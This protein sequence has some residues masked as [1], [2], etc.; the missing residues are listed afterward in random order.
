MQ[1]FNKYYPPDYDPDKH[2]SLNSYR[3]THALGDR[4]RKLDQGILITRFELPF[5]IWCL[6]CNNHI[7]MGVRYNAEKRKIGNYYSTPMYAFRCKCHLC[8]NWFEIRTDPKNTRY[9]VEYGARQKMEDWNPEENGGYAIHDPE[10]SQQPVDPLAAIEKTTEAIKHAN[11]VGAPRLEELYDLSEHY[12]ADPYELSQKVRR[13]FREEKKVDQAQKK[14]DDAFKDK[15]AL[16]S[17][18]PLVA[19]KDVADEAKEEWRE[20]RR[21]LAAERTEVKPLPEIS[22]SRTRRTSSSRPASQ[23]ARITST[24]GATLLR[25]TLRKSDPGFSRSSKPP[26]PK[27]SLGLSL[28][29]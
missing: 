21:K 8:D 14:A 18:M 12:N 15:Y 13:R 26:D 1:G 7:G 9:V 16:P 6:G 28:K 27:R 29:R 22:F 2:T 11:T 10:A 17:A 5:N 20:A 23:S 19:E 25:N 4:A 3:G 24:L